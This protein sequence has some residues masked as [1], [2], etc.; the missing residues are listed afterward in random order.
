M[1]ERRGQWRLGSPKPPLLLPPRPSDF[2]DG[3]HLNF[4]FFLVLFSKY[5]FVV[6]TLKMTFKS[7]QERQITY[8][9]TYMWNLKQDANELI[10]ET[11]IDL[12][13]QKG[14]GGGGG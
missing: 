11:D 5:F 2:S 13:I 7:D 10:Y 1:K 8:D 3:F 12:Q 6:S 4:L 14:D 9:T